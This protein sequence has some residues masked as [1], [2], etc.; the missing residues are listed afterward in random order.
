MFDNC[1]TPVC[2]GSVFSVCVCSES[3]SALH[4]IPWP[5]SVA[6]RG[7]HSASEGEIRGRFGVYSWRQSRNLKSKLRS[8]DLHFNQRKGGPIKTKLCDGFGCFVS[9]AQQLLLLV[10]ECLLAAQKKKINRREVQKW[11]Y[12]GCCNILTCGEVKMEKCC[13]GDVIWFVA[14]TQYF[15][16]L[17]V[18]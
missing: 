4:L 1:M 10:L 15:C 16:F 12:V 17:V 13:R 18:K 7:A 8:E 11:E 6:S 14:E 5:V 3:S 2:V 9:R